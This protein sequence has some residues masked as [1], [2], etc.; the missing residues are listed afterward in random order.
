MRN[1]FYLPEGGEKTI[2]E[3]NSSTNLFQNK[4]IKLE[5]LL[6]PKINKSLSMKKIYG[7]KDKKESYSSI[8]KKTSGIFYRN[9][10]NQKLLN[11]SKSAVDIMNSNRNPE[12]IIFQQ[13]FFNS[14]SR[15][16]N[17]NYEPNKIFNKSQYYEKIIKNNLIKL[18]ERNH[19][20]NLT[21]YLEKELNNNKGNNVILQIY[22][23]NIKFENLKDKKEYNTY[24]PFSLI[25]IFYSY[26]II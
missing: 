2:I 4:D 17:L 13:E 6:L 3:N 10:R 24:L 14:T 15:F 12:G 21:Y 22:S 26:D 5:N 20:E 9:L 7:Y 19:N 1:K 11:V 16:Y 23:I 8:F 18:K 25:P